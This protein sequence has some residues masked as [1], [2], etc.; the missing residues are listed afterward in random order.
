[1]GIGILKNSDSVWKLRKSVLAYLSNTGRNYYYCFQISA[2]CEC[3]FPDA[4]KAILP[5]YVYLSKIETV[6]KC[7]IISVTFSRKSGLDHCP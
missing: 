2:A 6:F 5:G 7:V 1:M 3:P 4:F